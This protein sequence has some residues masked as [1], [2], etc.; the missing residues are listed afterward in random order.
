MD[1]LCEHEGRDRWL[2]FSCNMGGPFEH[3][4][5]D[6]LCEHDGPE[7]W[8]GRVNTMA[9]TGASSFL[10]SWPSRLNIMAGTGNGSCSI[11]W[12]RRLNMR[13]FRVARN[14]DR[15]LVAQFLWLL[16]RLAPTAA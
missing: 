16:L 7:S 8:T 13:V 4:G 3:E 2:L 10:A 14:P 6:W 9:V 15:T 5:R 1:G 11:T 12:P